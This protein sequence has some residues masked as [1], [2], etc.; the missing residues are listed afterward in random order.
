[1]KCQR[2]VE[3]SGMV[4]HEA[5][6]HIEYWRPLWAFAHLRAWQGRTLEC[7]LR[8]TVPADA[9]GVC[10]R[11]EVLSVVPREKVSHFSQNS[12]PSESLGTEGKDSFLR[13]VRSLLLRERHCV[14][15]STVV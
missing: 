14:G 10:W 3:R 9:Q 2:G 4:A 6:A 8:E 12:I 15:L 11:W 1:M 7:C 13:S 5:I